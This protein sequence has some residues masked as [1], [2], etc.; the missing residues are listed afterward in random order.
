MVE[1]VARVCK[2]LKKAF[3][4]FFFSF[5]LNSFLRQSISMLQAV[6]ELCLLCRPAGLEHIDVPVST[7]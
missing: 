1:H 5:L 4:F 3:P 7:S 6:L 2:T